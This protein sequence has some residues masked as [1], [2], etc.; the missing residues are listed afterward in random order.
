MGYI[1]F[2][3]SAGNRRQDRRTLLGLCLAMAI[4]PDFDFLP[5]ILVGQPALYHQGVTHSLGA[6]VV[7]GLTLALPYSLKRN[8]LIANWSRFG[9]AY[10]S[11]LALDL[12]G[13]DSRPPYGIPL[14]WPLSNR[15]YLASWK[16]FPG[17]QHADSSAATTDEWLV[18]LLNLTNLKAFG[19]EILVLLP[20]VLLVHA[21]ATRGRG[22]KR[23]RPYGDQ[24]R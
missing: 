5:G 20:L 13:E 8:P 3:A 11:H 7:A 6:T 22:S 17:V 10:A 9:M 1:V 23:R 18:G 15:S 2:A 16:I 19:V 14:F 24:D 4:A 12:F 21:L